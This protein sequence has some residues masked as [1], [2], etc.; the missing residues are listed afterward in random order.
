MYW[1]EISS[2]AVPRNWLG[3]WTECENS[4][5]THSNTCAIYNC[6]PERERCTVQHDALA[7]SQKTV[8]ALS[9]RCLFWSLWD[10]SPPLDTGR[11]NLSVFLGWES[12]QFIAFLLLR[13]SQL[14]NHD[15]RKPRNT[16]TE[17]TL[18]QNVFSITSRTIKSVIGF[19]T[20]LIKL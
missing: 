15:G 19:A 1:R 13:V 3:V 4:P 12:S 7:L 6:R 14:K 20:I 18:D 9:V 10:V 17:T 16:E 8:H 2:L 5:L 11:R